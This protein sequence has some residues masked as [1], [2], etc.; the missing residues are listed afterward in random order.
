MKTY[1]YIYN[2]AAN[3]L[4]GSFAWAWTV[5]FI[6]GSGKSVGWG[7]HSTAP[8]LIRLSSETEADHLL[9]WKSMTDR[10]GRILVQMSREDKE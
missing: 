4:H 2:N 1:M 7:V 3:C 5:I 9:S 10:T 6:K 8:S